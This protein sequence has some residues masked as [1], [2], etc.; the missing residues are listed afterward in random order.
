MPISVVLGSKKALLLPTLV[1]ESQLNTTTLGALRQECCE[2]FELPPSNFILTYAG[3]VMKDDISSLA[4][5][6]LN[7]RSK[8]LMKVITPQ[9]V[10]GE[11]SEESES[12]SPFLVEFEA[13]VRKEIQRVVDKT[14]EKSG[15][16]VAGFPIQVKQFL[17]KYPCP[18]PGDADY[19]KSKKQLQDLYLATNETLLG[20]LM[21]L[22]GIL[23]GDPARPDVPASV[24]IRDQRK[25]AVYH[26]QGLLD[27]LDHVWNQLISTHSK[28]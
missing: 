3:V 10:Q 4:S 9:N 16:A 20:G 24:V 14:V 27:R 8:V 23:S 6:G 21:Q 12:K 15:A 2:F 22:D 7:F 1:N 28:L 26:L 5:Y 17:E 25:A 19:K 13:R 18:I 11:Q